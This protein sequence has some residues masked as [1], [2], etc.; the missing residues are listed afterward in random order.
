[1]KLFEILIPCV[2]NNGKPVKT[3]QHKEWDRR[4]RRITG[5]G[6]TVLPPIKGQWVSPSGELFAD[7]MII[8]RIIAT[9]S[10]MEIISDMTAQFYDQEAV[11]FFEL[12][13][14][15]IIKKYPENR[16]KEKTW[17]HQPDV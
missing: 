11:M 5:D 8:V 12:S 9:Y 15:V 16:T 13:N 10:Q 17:A 2:K 7:R 3:K 1:M 6:L 14:E 4:V